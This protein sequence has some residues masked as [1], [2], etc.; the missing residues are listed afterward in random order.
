[1]TLVGVHLLEF[2]V[3]DVAS[4]CAFCVNGEGRLPPQIKNWR[5]AAGLGSIT[6]REQ[7]TC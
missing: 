3:G 1:M 7:K 2:R 5:I 4:S 6:G